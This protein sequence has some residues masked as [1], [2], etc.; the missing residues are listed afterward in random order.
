MSKVYLIVD[1]DGVIT[2][3]DSWEKVMEEF[4]EVAWEAVYSGIDSI[5]IFVAD[6][7]EVVVSDLTSNVEAVYVR[8]GYGLEMIIEPNEYPSFEAFKA[9]LVRDDRN[10]TAE[11]IGFDVYALFNLKKYKTK[12]SVTM[13]EV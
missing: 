5:S 10:C 6:A 12:L 3:Y 9:D 4:E 7:E 8:Y 11:E 13:E 1:C 2:N